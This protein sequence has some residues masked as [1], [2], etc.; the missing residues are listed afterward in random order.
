[1]GNLGPSAAL[2]DLDYGAEFKPEAFFYEV[3]ENSEIVEAFDST[4]NNYKEEGFVNAEE[5]A[6]GLVETKLDW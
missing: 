3:D 1:M 5:K 6:T 4:P 2:I